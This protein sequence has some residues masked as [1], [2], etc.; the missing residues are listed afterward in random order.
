MG[1]DDVGDG[2]AVATERD[3]AAANEFEGKGGSDGVGIV[4]PVFGR[5]SGQGEGLGVPHLGGFGDVLAGHDDG[6]L[7][8]AMGGREKDAGE[9]GLERGVAFFK[10]VEYEYDAA[11][12]AQVGYEGGGEL[13][14]ALFAGLLVGSSEGGGDFVMA[15]EDVVGDVDGGGLDDVLDD[16]GECGKV[17]LVECVADVEEGVGEGESAAFEI[18]DDDGEVVG[19]AGAEFAQEFAFAHAA[20]GLDEDDAGGCLAADEAGD[21]GEFVFTVDTRASGVVEGHGFSSMYV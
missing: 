19:A 12:G 1:F 11:Q 2:Q 20:G 3:T 9:P 13:G 21:V 14:A 15:D 18:H 6:Q 4:L 5:D 16:L 7:G 8:G 10:G 17:G